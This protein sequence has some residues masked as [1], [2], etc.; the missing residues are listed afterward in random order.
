M[1]SRNYYEIYLLLLTI[2]FAGTWGLSNTGEVTST[3][4][5]WA[6]VV[7]YGGLALSAIAAVIGEL[8]FTNLSLLIERA[9]LLLLT[10]LVMAYALA[11]I[12]V[13]IRISSVSHVVYVGVALIL[14]AVINYGR[15]R[16]VRRGMI[17]LRTAYAALPNRRSK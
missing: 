12:I 13:G 16:Q 11:F 17:V 4:P 10:G 6:R 2:G 14:F 9:A 5:P 15:A 8:L 7:W 1:I 3:F